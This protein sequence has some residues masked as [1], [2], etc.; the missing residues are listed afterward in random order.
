MIWGIPVLTLILVTGIIYTKKSG[1]IQIR[2]FPLACKEFIRSLHEHT[3]GLSGYRALCTALAATVGTGNIVGV[4]GAIALGGP[5]VVF[6]MWICA[7]LGM[8][9]KFAEVTLAMH[10]REKNP[11]GEWVGGPMYMIKNG[12][13]PRLSFLALI[14]AFFGVVA[15][16]GIGNATQMNAVIGGIHI[17]TNSAG[18]VLTPVHLG[19]IAV[20]FGW[21]L[22]PL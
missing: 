22:F 11:A 1:S 18:K 19:I 8:V 4:A 6:W 3:E 21:I 2:L 14:Y 5:G 16:F 7:I 10:F 17:L 15:S 13:S 9:I 12:L 20:L